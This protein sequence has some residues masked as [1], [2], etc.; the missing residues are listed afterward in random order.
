M[1]NALRSSLMKAGV[2]DPTIDILEDEE[3]KKKAACS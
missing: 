3:V 2:K 1:D